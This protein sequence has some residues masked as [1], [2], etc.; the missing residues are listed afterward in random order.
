M[1]NKLIIHS[2]TFSPISTM[3]LPGRMS[4]SGPKAQASRV[5]PY[6]ILFTSFPKRML[7][8]SVAFWIQACWGTYATLPCRKPSTCAL[9]NTIFMLL[10]NLILITCNFSG[11]REYHIHVCVYRRKLGRFQFGGCKENDQSSKLNSSPTLLGY[12][13]AMSNQ[14]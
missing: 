14:I 12:T 11:L 1:Y 10:Q 2:P 7:S 4:R 3:S 6:L 8:F 9:I 13:H 5:L